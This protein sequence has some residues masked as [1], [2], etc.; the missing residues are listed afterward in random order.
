[1]SELSIADVLGLA[2]LYVVSALIA[3]WAWSEWRR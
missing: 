3:A 2:C 1:M